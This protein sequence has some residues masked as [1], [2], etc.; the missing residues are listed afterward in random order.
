MTSAMP[1]QGSATNWATKALGW[2]Q[3]NF[4]GSFVP[5]EKDSMNGINVYNGIAEVTGSNQVAMAGSHAPKFFRFFSG[6][7]GF[8]L[9]SKTN[10][11]GYLLIWFDFICARPHKLFSFKHYRV[12]IKVLFREFSSKQP[13]TILLSVYVGSN[14]FDLIGVITD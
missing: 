9:L 4:L 7:S 1:V 2:E 11:I 13:W 12:K 3:V 8:P 6:Y 5:A 10:M 14:W